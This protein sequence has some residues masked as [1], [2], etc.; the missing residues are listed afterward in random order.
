MEE[1]MCVCVTAVWGIKLIFSKIV[2]ISPGSRGGVHSCSS[3]EFAHNVELVP[4]RGENAPVTDPISEAIGNTRPRT[5]SAL[6]SVLGESL[7]A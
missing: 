4:L 3:Q 2:P 7:R 5:A 6:E 1:V